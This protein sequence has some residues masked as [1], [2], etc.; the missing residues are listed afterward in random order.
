MASWIASAFV[1]LPRAQLQ[2]KYQEELR[3]LQ[4]PSVARRRHVLRS[5][6]R[7]NGRHIPL[8]ASHCRLCPSSFVGSR[9]SCCLRSMSP[10]PWVSALVPV[11]SETDATTTAVRPRSLYVVA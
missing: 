2:L 7:V 6:A 4:A 1:R 5:C 10:V 8:N 3:D 11:I 9:F